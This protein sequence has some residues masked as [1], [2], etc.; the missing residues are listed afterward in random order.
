MVS[1]YRKFYF[2]V[3]KVRVLIYC[4]H[5]L[6]YCLLHLNKWPYI[7]HSVLLS[8]TFLALQWSQKSSF[9][10]I[11][12]IFSCLGLLLKEKIHVLASVNL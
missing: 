2:C 12:L 1:F 8:L 5:I 9:F 4:K 11:I 3:E 6:K 10:E 7:S